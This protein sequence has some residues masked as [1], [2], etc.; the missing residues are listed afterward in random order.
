MYLKTD[1]ILNT[2][3]SIHYTSFVSSNINICTCTFN[4][5]NISR[6]FI[7]AEVFSFP[8][9][10]HYGGEMKGVNNG[11]DEV[12]KFVE[13]AKKKRRKKNVE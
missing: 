6:I 12:T 3:P 11:W 13:D 4:W 10:T 7:K 1:A 8:K 5:V 2:E 9:Q